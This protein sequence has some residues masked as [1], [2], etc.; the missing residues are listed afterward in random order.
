MIQK[1]L[2]TNNPC[3]FY[4]K[5]I[6]IDQFAYICPFTCFS[7][8]ISTVISCISIAVLCYAMVCDFDNVL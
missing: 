7:F 1:S 8:S 2:F 3:G 5:Y 4:R 6:S